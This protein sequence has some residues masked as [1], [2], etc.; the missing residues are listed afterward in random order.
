MPDD[1]QIYLSAEMT[2]RLA[3][4]DIGS[5][6][7]R[8]LVAEALRGGTYRILDEEREPTRL[9]RSVAAGALDDESMAH[10]LRALG[11]FRQI[12]AGYQV[13]TLRTI[14]TCA[15]REA[16]NGPD[17]CRRVREEVGLD[18]EVITSER[19]ARL[20]FSSVQNAFDLTGKNVVV[21]DIGGGS[22]EV[23]FATGNLIEAIH[24]TPL[25]AVRLTEQFGAGDPPDPEAFL[26]LE[27]EVAL[28]L[29]KRTSRPLFAP[30]FLVGSGGT[31]TTLAELV[32]ASKGEVN[33]PVAGYRVSHAEVRHLLDRLRK[34]PV[35]AR[36]ALPGMAP[37][38]ADII[39]AGLSIIDGLLKRF[40]VNTL[41]VHTRGVRDGLMREMIDD[42]LGLGAAPADN[43]SLRE[44]AI[45]RLAGACSGE[46]EHG[47]KVASLAGRI[48]EQLA[49]P[50]GVEADDRPLLECAARLQDVGYVINY[51]QHH[52]HSY[53][54]I[55]N[56]RLPGVRPHDLE[57]IANVARYHRGAHPK[58]KHENLSRLSAADQRRVHRMAAV[59]RL[60]GG[61]DR[62]RSQQVRDVLVLS[63]DHGVYLDV[64]SDQEPQV[65][66]WGAERRTDLF[67]KV[68][69][70]KVKLR[71]AGSEGTQR[72]GSTGQPKEK[73]GRGGRPS[74]QDDDE[75][76]HQEN[77]RLRE[78]AEGREPGQGSTGIA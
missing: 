73:S 15:V 45:E 21:A 63:D 60:A 3:A 64:V 22:T 41:M 26:R 68:F 38:R 7:V 2:S 47:R 42:V 20:A 25:G 29:K 70:T 10:T 48:W 28:C 6:S 13:T 52:K 76:C 30:H 61:L 75:Q 49:T 16:R 32:M 74:E 58:K 1:K 36:R 55:R 50:L 69:S 53:H 39:V 12:A 14:A 8:L 57:L 24:P 4:I 44:E 71:W 67:E 17:F 40:R 65:D 66:I 56:S 35:R 27:A 11:S 19:E 72:R 34:L 18:V 51:D 78:V 43:A 33:I 77:S 5:N 37:D 46:V 62:S 9:G 54:L 23:V 31:F 59:L